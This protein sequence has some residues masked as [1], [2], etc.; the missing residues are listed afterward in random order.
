MNLQS[1]QMMLENQATWESNA[2]SYPRKN[3]LVIKKAQGVYLTDIE[4]KHI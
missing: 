4:N 3:P 2:R 1:Q